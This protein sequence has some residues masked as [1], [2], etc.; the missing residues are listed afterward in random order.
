MFYLTLSQRTI[1]KKDEQS[2]DLSQVSSLVPGCM[3]SLW[4]LMEPLQ[5]DDLYSDVTWICAHVQLILSHL[6]LHAAQNILLDVT[7]LSRGISN[8]AQSV[9]SA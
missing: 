2:S 9:C 5:Q 8:L 4:P 3:H 6:A 1:Y 7:W